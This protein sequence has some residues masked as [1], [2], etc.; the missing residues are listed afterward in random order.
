MGIERGAKKGV[1]VVM[2]LDVRNHETS[3]CC[4]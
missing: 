1:V 4:R 2:M 3:K